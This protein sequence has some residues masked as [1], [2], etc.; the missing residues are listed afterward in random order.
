MAALPV[1]IERQLGRLRRLLKIALFRF[2]T[3]F[4]GFMNLKMSFSWAWL[5]KNALIDVADLSSFNIH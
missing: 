5:A 4:I 1:V 2:M 3:R